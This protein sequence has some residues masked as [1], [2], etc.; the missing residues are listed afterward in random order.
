MGF[1]DTR[2]LRE[3][4][5]CSVRFAFHSIDPPGRQC[6]KRG[7]N[8]PAFF[9]YV[10]QNVIDRKELETYWA[11]IGATL[12][13]YGAKSIVAYTH[14]KHLEGDEVDGAAVIEFPTFEK[15]KEWYDSPAYRAIRHHRMN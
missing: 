3:G 1:G 9:V 13:G 4:I 15:A 5:P 10:C 8:M 12:E 6:T 2:P 14:F 7:E 11:K